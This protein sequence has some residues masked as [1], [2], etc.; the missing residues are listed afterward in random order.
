MEENFTF[1]IFHKLIFFNFSKV[2]NRVHRQ[3]KTS[4][5]R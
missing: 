5:L 3:N 4:R 1:E 2:L